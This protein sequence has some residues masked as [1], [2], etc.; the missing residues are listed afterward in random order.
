MDKTQKFATL[1]Y[2]NRY[3]RC[4]IFPDEVNCGLANWAGE[5]D[6]K[7]NLY[8]EKNPKLNEESDKKVKTPKCDKKNTEKHRK[9]ML[10]D[11]R[12]PKENKLFYFR[13]RE[14]PILWQLE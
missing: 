14:K 9:K 3:M 8:K 2:Q 12:N 10:G 5:Q 6:T 4:D 1:E 13:F 7:I 11:K